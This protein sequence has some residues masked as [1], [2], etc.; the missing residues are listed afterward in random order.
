MQCAKSNVRKAEV[1]VMCRSN[2]CAICKSVQPAA[3]VQDADQCY[4]QYTKLM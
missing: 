4:M 2:E 3:N 1:I